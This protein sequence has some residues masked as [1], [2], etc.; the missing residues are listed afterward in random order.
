MLFSLKSFL[1]VF[2]SFLL[3]SCGGS[4]ENTNAENTSNIEPIQP[5]PVIEAPVEPVIKTLPII[6]QV[7]TLTP[8]IEQYKKMEMVIDLTAQYTN[9]YHQDEISIDVTFTSPTQNTFIT[10]AFWDG[11]SNWLVRFTPSLAGEWSYSLLAKDKE[12]TSPSFSGEFAVSEST[13]SGWLQTGKQFNPSYSNKYLVHHDGTPF[14]GIGHADAFIVDRSFNRGVDDS[15]D[16]LIGNMKEANEN[17][18]V[19]WPL[20]YFSP[21]ENNY[22]DFDLRN[23]QTIDTFLQRLEQENLFTVF[24]LWDHSQLRDSNH[25][26]PEGNWLQ[27]NGFSDLSS[28]S[29]FFITDN[30]WLW[31]RN[32]YRYIIA[33]YGYSTSIAMWQ[34]VSEIDGTN[35]FENSDEWHKKVNN[36]F[37]NN[38]PYQHPTTAS[39]AGDITWSEGHNIMGIPQVH[40]YQDLLGSD[41]KPLTTHTA[42]FI[43]DYTQNMWQNYNKP[44]WV[45]EFGVI[46]HSSS[47]ANYYPELFHNAIWAALSNG[48]ALTPAEW[49]DFF[50]WDI[51]TT[52]MKNH[53]RYL[54]VFVEN[55]PLAQWDPSPIRINDNN[56]TTQSW[57]ILGNQGGIIWVQDRLVEGLDINDIREQRTIRN[58]ISLFL[59]DVNVGQYNVSPFNTWN[60]QFENSFIIDCNTASIEGCEIALPNFTSD[61]AIR[62]DKIN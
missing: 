7:D 52:A 4:S 51:M 10:P 34:T 53:M 3:T 24:T 56:N 47:N 19:W 61:I 32:L 40:I 31:Q 58:S 60:G 57:G 35:A 28:L 15:L 16:D 33:R 48:A 22:D 26:W 49:N 6:N 2:I 46:T 43:A 27:T 21:V 25:P 8:I 37:V 45:G 44:S 39:M 23:L 29:D 9:P 5:P 1:V 20:F 14:Y 38:D 30:A 18:F 50:D 62:L 59:P 17:Y 36:Y 54:N 55:I 42:N 12:G 41:E 11:E 13:S